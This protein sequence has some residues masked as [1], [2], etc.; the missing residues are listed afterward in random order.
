[1]SYR[2]KR[3]KSTTWRNHLIR[4]QLSSLIIHE[5]LIIE[6]ERAKW[7]KR[8]FDKIMT[9]AKKQNLS[10]RRRIETKLFPMK[11]K[12]NKTAAY[13]LYHDLTNR[14]PNRNS[15]YTRIVRIAKRKGDNAE[16]ALISLV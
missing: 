3:G 7:L 9:I 8:E 2:L 4:N 16:L 5:K 1:M 13:K 15:G 12:D 6:V 11:T 10:S 14:Y